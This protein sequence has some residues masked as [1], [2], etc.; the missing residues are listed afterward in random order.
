MVFR[1]ARPDENRSNEENL[2]VP[3][4]SRINFFRQQNVDPNEVFRKAAV[5]GKNVRLEGLV[6]LGNTCYLNAAVQVSN[7]AAYSKFAI[8]SARPWCR[9]Q[10]LWNL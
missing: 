1:V 5:F 2:L 4:Q 7:P 8:Y 6:N 9:C 3:G 10:V